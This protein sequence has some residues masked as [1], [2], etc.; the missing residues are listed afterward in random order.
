MPLNPF[1]RHIRICGCVFLLYLFVDLQKFLHSHFLILGYPE[2][3]IDAPKAASSTVLI[4]EQ[5][6]ML[7]LHKRR[8]TGRHGILTHPHSNAYTHTHAHTQTPK[9]VCVQVRF[10]V[11]DRVQ[12][13]NQHRELGMRTKERHSRFHRRVGGDVV[14]QL[15]RLPGRR[16]Q[17]VL[18]RERE[19]FPP[20]HQEKSTVTARRGVTTPDSGDPVQ[21][22]HWEQ[23]YTHTHTH[24]HKLKDKADVSEYV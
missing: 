2:R 22:Q 11:N 18:E 21:L 20:V 1:L 13:P 10:T 16:N 4:E 9:S 6:L 14:S 24:T 19:V 5:V 8:A 7:Y 15:N 23:A 17:K 12:V 3:S